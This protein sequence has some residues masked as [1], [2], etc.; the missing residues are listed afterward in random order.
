MKNNR[1]A[2]GPSAVGN[3][4][5]RE[6]EMR[7]YEAKIGPEE[8]R[9]M[10][11]NSAH[12]DNRNISKERV[13]NYAADMRNGAWLVN[14]EPI[15]MDDNA[16]V[17]DGQHRL[18]A[19]IQS[20]ATVAFLI[21]EGVPRE[22]ARTIDQGLSRTIAHSMQMGG[23][24]NA[25]LVVAAARSL[26]DLRANVDPRCETGRRHNKQNGLA[27]ASEVDE[28]LRSDA[29]GIEDFVEA[30]P[31]GASKAVRLS[32][33]AALSFELALMES[34][35]DALEWASG[36][37]G[38]LP[39]TD[40]RQ[41]LRERFI[42]D[43]LVIASRTSRQRIVARHREQRMDLMVQ[44]WNL[45]C[46]GHQATW[47]SFTSRAEGEYRIVIPVRRSLSSSRTPNRVNR[48]TVFSLRN[49]GSVADVP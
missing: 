3:Q 30:M 27:T 23:H 4:G 11:G 1:R 43:R 22:R 39:A 5:P 34:Q 17:I 21:V 25:V 14:G 10:L 35:S 40:P 7:T 37:E 6:D 49:E 44:S 13:R 46:G 45:W 24:K 42:D 2:V 9:R 16:V 47:R 29:K 15:I 20:G 32:E 8:A 31:R 19:V 18:H 12:F 48:R 38:G 41:V 33:L 26:H 36:F 28:F